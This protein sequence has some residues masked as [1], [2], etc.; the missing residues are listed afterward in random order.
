MIQEIIHIIIKTEIDI[1]GQFIVSTMIFAG[2][3]IDLDIVFYR[4]M[5]LFADQSISFIIRTLISCHSI[6]FTMIGKFHSPDYA[7][8]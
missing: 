4:F 2:K 8:I 6:K 7:I 3:T 1:W 5:E